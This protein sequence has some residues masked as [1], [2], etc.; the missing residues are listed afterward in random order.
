MQLPFDLRAIFQARAS[1]LTW[2]RLQDSNVVGAPASAVIE[3]EQAY[4]SVC[5]KEMYVGYSR[6]LWIKLYPVLYSFIAHGGDEQNTVAGPGQLREFGDAN[7]ERVI[8]LNYGLT[9]PIVYRGSEVTILIGL[10][11]I[12]GDDTARVLIDL[13]ASLA[14]LTGL[15]AGPAIEATRLVKSSIEKMLGLQGTT[16]QLGVRDTVNAGGSLR[17]GFYV[18]INAPAGSVPAKRMWL[19]DGHLLYGTDPY[20]AEP[21]REHDYMVVEVARHEN[22]SDWARLPG[23]LEFEDKFNAILGDSGR[24]VAQ[25]REALNSAFDGFREALATSKQLTGPDR[26]Y[27]ESDVGHKLTQR[28]TALSSPL[29]EKKG[30]GAPGPTAYAALDFGDV[31]HSAGSSGYAKIIASKALF[32]GD[33]SG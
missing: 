28:V 8:N 25:K 11:S 24:T 4:F 27:I 22:R 18:G 13:T 29:F 15:A 20:V 10:Y 32:E 16:L 1:Q 9:S 2:E 12:R 14:G 26:S 23:I 17:T 33:H 30:F 7:L 19:K 6:K 5:L 31:V 21:Y 3:K